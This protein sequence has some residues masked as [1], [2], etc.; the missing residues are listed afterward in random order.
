MDIN[1]RNFIST[2]RLFSNVQNEWSRLLL[3]CYEWSRLFGCLKHIKIAIKFLDDVLKELNDIFCRAPRARQKWADPMSD[4]GFSLSFCGDLL[5][6]N[7]HH[8]SF[9][10]LTLCICTLTILQRKLLNMIKINLAIRGTSSLHI[11]FAM[12]FDSKACLY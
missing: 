12:T 4:T 3:D 1:I 2:T 6:V 10:H 8:V 5:L 11:L 7:V 9:T